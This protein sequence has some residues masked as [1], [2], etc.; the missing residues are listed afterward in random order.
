MKR[1]ELRMSTDDHDFIIEVNEEL[2]HQLVR[3]NFGRAGR[4]TIDPPSELMLSIIRRLQL[5][6]DD[7]TNHFEPS[8]DDFP[9][10]RRYRKHVE[11]GEKP[12][13]LSPSKGGP[14]WP[15]KK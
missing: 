13:V 6:A 1:I 5:V 7:I 12:P 8:P 14:S 4:S 2:P 11:R 3:M 10:K 15:T 9:P